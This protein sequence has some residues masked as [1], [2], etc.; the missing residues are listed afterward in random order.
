MLDCQG[1]ALGSLRGV[2]SPEEE[3]QRRPCF[4][5]GEAWVVGWDRGHGLLR[6]WQRAGRRLWGSGCG[7]Q[8]QEGPRLAAHKPEDGEHCPAGL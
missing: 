4:S 7:G 6:G 2:W 8:A 5:L 1:R 3:V